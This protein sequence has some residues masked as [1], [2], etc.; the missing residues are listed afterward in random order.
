[1]LHCIVVLLISLHE[2]ANILLAGVPE[3]LEVVIADFGATSPEGIE[4][5]VPGTTAYNPL[6]VS[7]AYTG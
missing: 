1:M 3:D 6:E 7:S 5:H 2:P 4:R